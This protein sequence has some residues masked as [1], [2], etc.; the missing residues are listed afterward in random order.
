MSGGFGLVGRSLGR[1]LRAHP[2]RAASAALAA[3][4]GIAM[5]TAVLTLTGAVTSAIEGASVDVPGVN[6][7]AVARSSTGMERSL[8]DGVEQRVDGVQVAPL[9]TVNTRLESGDPIVLV[10]ATPEA[11]AFLPGAA[12][13]GARG[14]GGEL[15]L[16]ASKGW[17][18]DHDARVGSTVRLRAPGGLLTGRIG[19]QMPGSVV[20]GGNSLVAAYDDV[21]AAY[22]RTGV[23]DVALVRTTREDREA[24]RREVASALQGA[25]SVVKPEE[26]TASYEEAFASVRSILSLF[27]MLAIVIAASVVFFT[28]RMTLND[29]RANVARLRLVGA[30]PRTL[31]GGAALVLVPLIAVSAAIG[32]PLG[33]A[34]GAQASSF[35]NDL[36]SLT[37]LAVEPE[38][39]VLMP[40]MGGIAAAGAIF[41]VALADSVRNFTKVAPI[42]ATF[43]FRRRNETVNVRL[44]A[45]VGA[46]AAVLSV[47]LLLGPDDARGGALLPLLVLVV[48]LSRLVPL[49]AGRL[50]RRGR[51]FAGWS[52]GAAL[53]RAPARV[54]YVVSAFALAVALA[55]GLQGVTDSL[56]DDIDASVA[57][58]T[59]ADVFIRP[60]EPG[61]TF[62]DE[63]F[64]PGS[65]RALAGLP[66][67]AGTGWFGST[68]IEQ[69]GSRVPLWTWAASEPRLLPDLRITDGPSG[70]ALWTTL[71]SGQVAVTANYARL[72][73]VEVAERVSLP[74][75]SGLRDFPV[76]AIVDD[77]VADRGAVIVAANT[78]REL[79]GTSRPLQIDLFLEPG[80]DRAQTLAA[81]R[82]ELRPNHPGVAVYDRDGIRDI[83]SELTG[84]VLSSFVAVGWVLALLAT[85]VCAAATLTGLT[86]RQREFGVLRLIGADRRVIRG[87]VMRES[88]ASGASA[89]L[90]GLPIGLAL[91]SAILEILSGRTGVS[92][93]VEL[94]WAA[95]IGLLPAVVGLSLGALFL[96]SPRRNLRPI[97]SALADE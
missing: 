57:A 10:G 16:V 89:W 52:A 70:G 75:A 88:I 36:V 4:F 22:D 62:Q 87:Q 61:K 78:F 84:N 56:K 2:R 63:T 85:L 53:E 6:W 46:G 20:S 81:V 47:A 79:T 30:S 68:T 97:A 15:S 50:V 73:D 26:A 92:P 25:A 44:W 27:S 3:I 34:F 82:D 29:A 33:V 86:V 21:E 32:A 35:T 94:P 59:K 80:A 11:A 42:D 96:A 43:A 95:G 55:I 93:P 1:S 45:V 18:D 31:A 8:V 40:V 19:G 5:T 66:G 24:A 51:S 90:I 14:S 49:A 76:G 48:A 13:G 60:A 69:Y 54:A 83:F 77:S 58:W 67:V 7:V 12:G 41:L 74:T 37:Q 65:D 23:A 71:S 17:L 91:V 39:P 9:L 64:A 38:T 28:W 72:H